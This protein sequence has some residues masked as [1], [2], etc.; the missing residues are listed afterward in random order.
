MFNLILLDL[1]L[2]EVLADIPH[3]GSAVVAYLVI[4]AFIGLI[5]LGNM[6][7]P[8]ASRSPGEPNG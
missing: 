5:V 3:D 2:R 1:T 4:G 8:P 6:K 7:K